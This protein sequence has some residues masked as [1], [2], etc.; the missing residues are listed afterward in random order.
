[1]L[2]ASPLIVRQLYGVGCC[3]I[4]QNYVHSTPWY[5][6]HAIGRGYHPRLICIKIPNKAV[7]LFPLVHSPRSHMYCKFLYAVEFVGIEGYLLYVIQGIPLADGQIFQVPNG[8]VANP[9]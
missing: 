6:Q 3:H 8:V 1:M 9:R 2:P 4:L 5:A 7:E